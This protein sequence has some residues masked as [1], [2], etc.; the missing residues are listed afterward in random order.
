M[1]NYFPPRVGSDSCHSCGREVVIT[2]MRQ[3]WDK[4]PDGKM[5]LVLECW[6]CWEIRMG[7]RQTLAEMLRAGLPE[8]PDLVEHYHFTVSILMADEYD[9][10]DQMV[11]Q[12]DEEITGKVL[13]YWY[14]DLYDPSA[15]TEIIECDDIEDAIARLK[16][17]FR[18]DA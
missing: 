9:N 4:Q 12:V 6:P 17:E 10:G 7:Q 8:M 1:S 15:C 5:S 13:L 2:A 14:Q 18:I 16:I 11:V 3:D